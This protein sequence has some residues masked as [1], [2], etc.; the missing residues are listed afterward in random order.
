L[1]GVTIAE[2]HWTRFSARAVATLATAL[3]VMLM[4]RFLNAQG[5]GIVALAEAKAA[6]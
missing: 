6:A 4:P 3:G 2:R 5:R 1:S